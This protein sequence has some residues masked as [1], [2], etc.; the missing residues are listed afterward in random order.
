LGEQKGKES[1]F[2]KACPES[3]KILKATPKNDGHVLKTK[4]SNPHFQ[5]GLTW[6]GEKLAAIQQARIEGQTEEW[7]LRNLMLGGVTRPTALKMME[8]SK[9]IYGDENADREVST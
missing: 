9:F 6:R 5:R 3:A 4:L 7:I 2:L 8:D 1:K